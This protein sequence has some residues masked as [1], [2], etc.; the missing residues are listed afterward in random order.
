MP[1]D[2]ISDQLD[3]DSLFGL[4]TGDA[5]T[6]EDPHDEKRIVRFYRTVTREGLSTDPGPW[7]KKDIA[8]YWHEQLRLCGYHVYL[9]QLVEIIH[10]RSDFERAKKDGVVLPMWEVVK[11]K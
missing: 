9:E 6:Q 1:T 8:E 7:T 4:A 5:N 2:F 3:I 10:T 11:V